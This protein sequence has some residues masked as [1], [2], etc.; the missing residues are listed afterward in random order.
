ML[1]ASGGPAQPIKSQM[2]GVTYSTG[3]KE[4]LLTVAVVGRIYVRLYVRSWF[5]LWTPLFQCLKLDASQLLVGG[6]S[7]LQ[8][9]LKQPVSVL[10]LHSRKCDATTLP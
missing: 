9:L 10:L 4:V 5:P 8:E 2:C 3:K 1:S 6:Y 7:T